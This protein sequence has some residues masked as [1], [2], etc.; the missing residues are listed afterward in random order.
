MDRHSLAFHMFKSAKCAF[1]QY[2]ITQGK[3]D[4]CGKTYTGM[5]LAVFHGVGGRT[6]AKKYL[7]GN[8]IVYEYTSHVLCCMD[9]CLANQYLF[10]E[11]QYC[12]CRCNSIK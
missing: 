11:N 8:T 6:F 10:V 7:V 4:I 2:G 3:C 5:D 9:C 1:L 12:F